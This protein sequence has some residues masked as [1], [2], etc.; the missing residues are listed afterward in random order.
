V[1]QL[2]GITED[3]FESAKANIIQ[4][5]KQSFLDKH[6]I[7][8]ADNDIQLSGSN[9]RRALRTGFMLQFTVKMP[10]NFKGNSAMPSTTNMSS[11]PASGPTPMIAIDAAA[12]SQLIISSVQSD[13]IAKALDVPSGALIVTSI[14]KPSQEKSKR[15]DCPAGKYVVAGM[16]ECTPCAP[17][18]AAPKGSSN[19]SNCNSGTYA[20]TAGNPECLKC[21]TG[22][23]QEEVESTMCLKCRP[24]AVTVDMGAIS[25]QE[26]VCEPGYFDCTTAGAEICKLDECN[27]CPFDASCDQAETLESLQAKRG[28]W[29]AVNHTKTFYQCSNFDAC[30]GGRIHS[31]NRDSQCNVGYVGVR[32][33]LCDYESG[34]AIHQPGNKCSKCKKNEGQHSVYL[35]VGVMCGL[36]LLLAATQ[37]RLWPRWLSRVKGVTVLNGR[38][39]GRS[40]KLT[41][42][43]CQVDKLN[44]ALRA[45]GTLHVPIIPVS[46]FELFSQSRNAELQW[47]AL[48]GELRQHWE[49]AEE[50]VR[51]K[52]EQ[53]AQQQ[54]EQY[55][56]KHTKYTANERALTGVYAVLL[57]KNGEHEVANVLMLG[58]D[59]QLCT[60]DFQEMYQQRVTKIK[61]TVQVSI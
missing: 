17:G 32:C 4:A 19:C 9:A 16:G 36:L 54:R 12:V 20:D 2:D 35:A 28:F 22:F 43:H 39:A 56:R 51:T 15:G 21:W 14:G 48:K 30:K 10:S 50:H 33:E 31:S 5:I 24:N 53:R 46:G 11:A 1:L 52:Y 26:C 45:A 13:E 38:H 55:D 34:Y 49:S 61:I 6:S 60:L 47:R 18:R 40:G 8:L 27:E 3:T 29:R 58:T 57:C 59:L 37:L 7:S 44:D 25:V 42:S 23:Y 41:G